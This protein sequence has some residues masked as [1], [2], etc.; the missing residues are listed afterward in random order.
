MT[1]Y[2]GNRSRS[3]MNWHGT[4]W[5]LFLLLFL[6]VL[7]MPVCAEEST[8]DKESTEQKS[9]NSSILLWPFSH[10]IQPA[11]NVAIYPFA[12]PVRYAL[13]NGLMDKSVDLVTFGKDRKIIV[14]PTMNLKP[15][16][17]T[18]LG[19][20]YRHRSLI[21]DRDYFV[22]QMSLYANGDL[23]LSS[24]YS[25]QQLLGFPLVGSFRYKLYMDSDD[26]FIIPGTKEEFIQPDSSLHLEWRLGMP[27]TESH[28]L[29]LEFNIG[30]K[31]IDASPPTSKKDSI[32]I[33]DKY[34]IA[35]RGLYQSNTQFPFG[36]SI[37]YDD[38]DY[39]YAPSRGSRFILSGNYVHVHKYGGL[40]Y[41]SIYSDIPGEIE[42][43]HKNHDFISNAIVFQHYFYFGTAKEYILS[44][45]ETRQSRKFYTDFSLEN[46][47]RVWHPEN[48]METLLERRVLAVQ[49][50]MDNI[51]EMEKGGAP[52][53]AFPRMNARYPLRGYGDAWAAYH[54]MGLSM[55]YRWPVDRYVDGVIFDEYGLHAPEINEWS[56]E[57]YYNS[58]GFGI[59]VRMPN[60]YLF[61][62]Q[63]G[64]HGLHGINFIMTI[65]PEFK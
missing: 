34:D 7:I 28:K 3:L 46:A 49:F 15:G 5:S 64:F 65:A 36:M 54:L 40:D 13:N 55:E 21:F 43:S 44:A 35:D 41:S 27:L 45:T 47:L 9:E 10:I 56:F 11:L 14:Y 25:K 39:A 60:L 32:L 24:R 26:N 52:Y 30:Q 62:V 61:R 58:W 22:H 1:F 19:F 20:T 33:D 16:S 18:Q 59:R 42:K 23:Y 50:R 37:V 63:V 51:W 38:L 4:T 17:Q 48:L 8:T 31:F 53:N 12:A 6:F 2:S 29:N 57:H